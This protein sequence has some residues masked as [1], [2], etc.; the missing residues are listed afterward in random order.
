MIE[1]KPS[2]YNAQSVYNQGGGGDGSFEVDIGG[3]VSQT[4]V[5]PPYLVPV[6]YIDTS[7]LSTSNYNVFPVVNKFT[8]KLSFKIKSVFSFDTAI[9]N[10]D[11]NIKYVTYYH[12]PLGSSTDGSWN[13]Y[14][15]LNSFGRYFYRYGGQNFLIEQDGIFVNSDKLTFTLDVN[16][17]LATLKDESGH[18]ATR[19]ET[20]SYNF[21][22]IGWCG[23]MGNQQIN[24]PNQYRGKFYYS[25]IKD[26]DNIVSLLIP[27]REKT[28]NKL[29]MVD[30]VSGAAASNFAKGND[31][32]VS[33]GPDVD[34]SDEIPGWIT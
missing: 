5:F 4:L 16:N 11:N 14:L 20:P 10:S 2:I 30:C 34:L 25:Y 17:G 1:N 19:N 9:I 33:F 22:N 27:A 6:K 12:A 8:T 13:V 28:T 32:G 7:G 24:P 18:V 23:V 15:G 29:F 26:G 31:T 3:G 21:G